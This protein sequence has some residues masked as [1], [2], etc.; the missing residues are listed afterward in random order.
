M[1]PSEVS[2][3]FAATF[4]LRRQCWACFSPSKIRRE[5]EGSDIRSILLSQ[6]GV[7]GVLVSAVCV[8]Y[9]KSN[10]KR[11]MERSK[12]E[13]EKGNVREESLVETKMGEN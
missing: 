7:D 6:S 10:K 5:R 1:E 2:G 11:E 4:F 9:I 12:K 13:A 3:F 8:L